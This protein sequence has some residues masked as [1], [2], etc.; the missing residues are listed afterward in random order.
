MSKTIEELCNSD[1]FDSR[2]VIERIEELEAE[3]FGSLSEDEKQELTDLREFAREG[4]DY[5]P[6]WQYGETFISDSY[7][8][9]YARELAKDI[10]AINREAA[11]PLGYIDWEAA[12]KALRMDYTSIEL[13]GVTFWARS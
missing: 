11:W 13:D 7:F 12:A 2:D 3:P 6:D 9:D 10:G 8:K 4:A 5:A 1:V